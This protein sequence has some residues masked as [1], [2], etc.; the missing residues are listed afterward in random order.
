[1]TRHP[2]SSRTHATTTVAPDDVVVAKALEASSWARQNS[3]AIIIGLI[4]LAI[5]AAAVI[6]YVSYRRGL[7]E[8][9][10]TELIELRQVAASGD[11]S[12]AVLQLDAF[13]DRFDGTA[14]A[15]EARLLLAQLQLAQGNAPQAI[16]AVE[17]LVGEGDPLMSASAGLLVAG[18]HEAA[19]QAQQAEQAY[20]RVAESAEMEFQQREALEDAAR[21]RVANGNTAGAV[22]LYDRLIGMVPEG[23]PDRDVYQMRRAEIM[24]AQGM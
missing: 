11:V 9:A 12:N 21:I 14:A 20:L 3:R 8:R 10:S 1:M 13:V 22:E 19:G 24:A 15:N 5:A 6:Y 4:V 23:S 18:A 2:A 16:E 17:P 7:Q